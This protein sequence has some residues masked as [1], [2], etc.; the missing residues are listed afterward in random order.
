[1][2]PLVGIPQTIQIVM[3]AYRAVFCRTAGFNHVSRYISGLLLSPNKTLQGMY[4]QWVWP[5]G[6]RVSRRA[7]HAAVFESGWE[8]EALM[9]THRQVVAPA[10]QGYG[11]AVLSLDWTFAHHPY[12]AK[13]YGAKAAYDYVNRC[14]SCYQTVVTAALSTPQR[15]D[16]VAV[17]VQCPNY[18]KEELAYLTMT[19]QDSYDEM[20]Q[21]HQR[22]EELLH[23]QK[24]R[25]AYRKRTE[26]AVTIVE[27]LEA[28]GQFPQADYAFDAGV[29]SRP[30]TQVIE[31]A[32][33][34]WVSEIERSRLILWQDQWQRVES[35]A[36]Q[37]RQ[38][39]PECF[40]PYEVNC[41]NGERRS[42]WAFSKTVRLKKYGR[43]RLV[44]I[45]ETAE[46]SDTPRFLLTDALHW[47]SSRVF[48][49]WSYRWPI[50]T[51]HEF[52][53][54]FAG[55]EAAQLRN[56]EA[57]KRHFCLSCVAQSMLQTADGSGRQSER[58]QFAQD[59]EQTIGQRLHTL[60][61]EALQQLLEMTQMLLMQGQSVEQILEVMMPA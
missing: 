26:I 39:H 48:A 21:V 2:L 32:G 55:F 11:R 50:E 10:H 44:I 5:Q 58:F 52:T 34:H 60:T 30:L 38:V 51:F 27:Q 19:A 31:A 9:R 23:Y 56:E 61:R 14:W 16:G 25:L 12:S 36:L 28:E 45:H 20:A 6:E 17:E 49:T 47:N 59:H 35:V 46:L 13:I 43:K 57:V 24:N 3:S 18:Q 53:K 15:V 7:M 29:L 8:P 4:S 41:R 33:K 54:Q 42:I 1:M 40:R 37:L 22:L